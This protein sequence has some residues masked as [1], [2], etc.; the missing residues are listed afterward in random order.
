MLQRR[1]SRESSRV[2]RHSVAGA[3]AYLV[4]PSDRLSKISQGTCAPKLESGVVLLDSRQQLFS[5]RRELLCVLPKTRRKAPRECRRLK[6][7]TWGFSTWLGR[8]L[9]RGGSTNRPARQLNL[10]LRPWTGQTVP[11][12]NSDAILVIGPIGVWS[13]G[14]NY[15]ATKI[16]KRCMPPATSRITP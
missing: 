13:I 14:G 1:C 10:R 5:E 11:R 16:Q 15:P 6:N 4:G 9:G 3:S 12:A 8:G 2:P 7:H